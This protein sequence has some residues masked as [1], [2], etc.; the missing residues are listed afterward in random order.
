MGIAMG[1][2]RWL[3]LF[4]ALILVPHGAQ[5]AP[6]TCAAVDEKTIAKHIPL[7]EFSIVSKNA[8]T[9]T[10]EV[11]VRAMGENVP[12]YVYQDYV[13]AG[14]MFKNKR[15]ITEEAL[16]H[17]QSRDFAA[18]KEKIEGL[19][20]FSYKP[21][22]SSGKVLYMVTDPDCPYCEAAKFKIKE[23]ADRVKFEVRVIL[24][25]LP[26]HEDAKAKVIKALCSKMD[27]PRY[28]AGDYQGDT[29]KEGE[30]TVSRTLALAES[31]EI[32]GTPLFIGRDGKRAIGYDAKQI[33]GLL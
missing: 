31:L 27:Y 10:C 29:C 12:L 24:F 11:I 9:D 16:S 19:V 20:A 33:E 1:K 30:D 15:H 2:Y 3:L 13:I 4:A 17:A 8:L 32:A 7:P 25:P 21:E 28:L 18:M 22:G 5:A 23:L 26:M 6:N 14:D